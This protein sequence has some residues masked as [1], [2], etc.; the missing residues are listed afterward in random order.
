MTAPAL[1]PTPAG[2]E[3]RVEAPDKI[4]LT[5][6][7]APLK[8]CGL[9]S[10]FGIL[11]TGDVT[12]TAPFKREG[13]PL[14]AGSWAGFGKLPPSLKEGTAGGHCLWYGGEQEGGA[15]GGCLS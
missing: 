2:A 5:L 8:V 7:W 6:P 9:Y 14:W 11:E 1:G 10:D 4:C 3:D 12:V 13:F 15:C